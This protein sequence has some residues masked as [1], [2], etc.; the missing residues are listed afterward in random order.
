M[1]VWVCQSDIKN[2][3]LPQYPPGNS[4]DIQLHLKRFTYEDNMLVKLT[5]SVIYP[6][7]LQLPSETYELY[8]VVAHIGSGAGGHYISFVKV[9]GKWYKCDDNRVRLA[10]RGQHIDP[11][12]YL[13]FYKRRDFEPGLMTLSF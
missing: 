3:Y 9:T 6:E 10:G 4:Y 8:G 2:H 13:L 5:N 7:T 12:A 1:P 11:N